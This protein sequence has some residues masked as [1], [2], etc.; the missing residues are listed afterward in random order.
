MAVVDRTPTGRAALI[1]VGDREMT[2]REF[3][4][5]LGLNSALVSVRVAGDRVEVTSSGYGHGVGMSQY[6]AEGL[7]QQGKTYDAILRHYYAGVE[8]RPLFAE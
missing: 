5:A 8:I 7:A 2:G 6:G 1:R 4:Q 3:R